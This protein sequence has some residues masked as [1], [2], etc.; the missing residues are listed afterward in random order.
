MP[1]TND[2][3]LSNYGLIFS[4]GDQQYPSIDMAIDW[5][6][7]MKLKG[8]LTVGSDIKSANTY[9]TKDTAIAPEYSDSATYSVDDY[10]TYKGLLY[11]CITAIS[12]A[13]TWDSTHWTE[14]TVMAEI[15][16]L[17]NNN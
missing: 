10:V 4:T 2:P 14:T 8:G 11:R 9:V 16:R 6:G 3:N 5:N 1:D 17:I 7:N 13:E 15:K 12:T